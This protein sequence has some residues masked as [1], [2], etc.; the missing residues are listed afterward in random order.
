M[1]FGFEFVDGGR[2]VLREAR[3]TLTIDDFLRDGLALHVAVAAMAPPE[4]P[5]YALIDLSEVQS[6]QVDTG[7][8]MSLLDL[9]ERNA[10]LVPELA[11]AIV[12]P[13]E[14]L[15]VLATRWQVIAHRLSWVSEVFATRTAAMQWVESRLHAR[16]V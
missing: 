11:L 3:G 16:S 14:E 12:A 13:R 9:N 4:R 2:G 1:P 10:E 6:V 8:L 7:G 5:R 15:L